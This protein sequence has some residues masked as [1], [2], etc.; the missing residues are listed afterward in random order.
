MQDQTKQIHSDYDRRV[1]RAIV[2]QT[3]SDDH[4]ERWSRAELETELNHSDPTVIDDALNC[5]E[6]EGVIEIAGETVQASRAAKHLDVLE[7][8]AL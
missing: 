3:L 8:I 2:S 7:L 5:L 6:S 4:D 1:Q